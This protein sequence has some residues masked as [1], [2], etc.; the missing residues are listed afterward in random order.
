MLITNV[1]D[2][3]TF[4]ATVDLGFHIYT[5]LRFRL[6]GINAVEINHPDGKRAKQLLSD[7]ILNQTLV[8]PVSKPD[9]YGRWLASMPNVIN[10]IID[11]MLGVPY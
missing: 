8:V 11:N 4:D 7:L 3:D 1:V 5:K 10:I 2:G 6:L 9:K